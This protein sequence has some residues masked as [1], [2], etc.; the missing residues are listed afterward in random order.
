MKTLFTFKFGSSFP[1]K[2]NKSVVFPELGG[3]NSNDNL[4]NT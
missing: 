4:E 2:A 1:A 3:P